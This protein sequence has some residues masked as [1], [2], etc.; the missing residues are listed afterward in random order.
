M[1]QDTISKCYSSSLLDTLGNL[2]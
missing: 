1:Q 2:L